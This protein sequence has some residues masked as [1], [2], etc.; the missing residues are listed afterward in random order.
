MPVRVAL[1]LRTIE[2]AFQTVKE[3]GKQSS[4]RKASDLVRP[5]AKKCH[6]PQIVMGDL[7]ADDK[8]DLLI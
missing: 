4:S 2:E 1:N 6:M 7:M 3:Q 5:T 8:G